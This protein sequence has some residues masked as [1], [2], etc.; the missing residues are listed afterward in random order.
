MILASQSPRRLKLMHIVGYSPRV[1]PAHVDESRLVNED[2]IALVERLARAKARAVAP[3]ATTYETVIGAD[4]IVWMENECLGKPIDTKDARVMLHRLSGVTHKV[5]SG[6]CILGRDCAGNVRERVFSETTAVTFYKLTDAEI[7]AYI[8]SGEPMD[9]AGA[10]AIQG[11]ARLFVKRV[12]GNYENV[13]GL[14]LARLV[15]ELCDF[16]RN[17]SGLKEP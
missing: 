5:S 1:I 8:R 14:P 4:T 11:G 12:D 6:V 13:I 7:E 16:A 2:P 3:L 9:K 10:Y 15:R 17:R